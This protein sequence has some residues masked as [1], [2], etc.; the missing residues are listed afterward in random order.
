MNVLNRAYFSEEQLR[1]AARNAIS[2]L[3]PGGIWIVGRTTSEDPPLHEV[4][5]F[6]KQGSGA[7]EV[8]SRVGPG[9][10]IEALA[11]KASSQFP[12]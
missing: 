8:V 1:R 10:E 6:R 12:V 2:H 3:Q 5:I 11:L 9:S 4:T 7:I